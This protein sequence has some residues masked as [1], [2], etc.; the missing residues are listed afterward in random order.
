M[1]VLLIQ[2]GTLY[3]KLLDQ[4]LP[5]EGLE[6][7]KICLTNHHGLVSNLDSQD[8]K[9]PTLSFGSLGQT[10]R[11]R[12]LH[13][14]RLLTNKADGLASIVMSL[15]SLEDCWLARRG[16]LEKEPG[17]IDRSL[18]SPGEIVKIILSR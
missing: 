7:L 18:A 13:V 11:L 12:T 9:Q 10:P 15:S 16:Q 8:A 17:A 1:L 3:Q 6:V 5:R 14:H 4:I 2:Y